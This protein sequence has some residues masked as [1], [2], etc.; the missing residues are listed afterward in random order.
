MTSLQP[1]HRRP[2]RG[3]FLG[4]AAVLL[5]WA[6]GSAQ[7]AAGWDDSRALALVEAA[8]AVRQASAVDSTLVAYQSRAQGFV[9]FFLDRPDEEEHTLIKAD[10]LAL[11]VYWRA[12]GDTRQRIVGMRDEKVLPTNIRYHLDHLTVVQDDFGDRIRMGDGDEVEAVVHPAAPGA[13][14]VYQYRLTDSLSLNY[15]GLTEPV[16][17]YQVQVRPRD[18]EAPGF[19]GTLYLDRASG[20]IVRM[21]F[22]FTP[23]SYVD[24]YLDYIR[25]SLDNALWLG[26]HWLPYRQEVELRRELPQLD[27]MAGSIIRGRWEVRGYEFNPELPDLLFSGPRVTAAPQRLRDS[28]VFD[29]DLYADLDASGL[30]P[31][32]SMEEIEAEVRSMALSGLLDGLAPLRL[33]VSSVSD[34]LRRDR[35]EGWTL[36]LGGVLRIRSVPLRVT[37]GFATAAE[38]PWLRGEA[39]FPAGS[40]KVSVQGHWNLLR[41]M[42]P[43]PGASRLV[44]TL[45]T[46]GGRDYLD[47]WWAGGGGAAYTRPLGSE[48]RL[49]LGILAERHRSGRLNLDDDNTSFRPVRPVAEGTL[50]AVDAGVERL[51]RGRGVFGSVGLLVGR[52]EETY[53]TLDATLG[54][55]RRTPSTPWEWWSALQGGW[56]SGAAPPQEL[57]LLGGRGT[58]PGFD[59]RG[60]VGNRYVLGSAWVRRRIA[61]PWVS[62]RLTASAGWSSL[63]DRALPAGWTGE[64]DP[65]LRGSAGAGLDLLWDVIQLDVARGL[66]DGD[67]TLFLSITARFRPWL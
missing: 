31:S 65:G 66:P 41:D 1:T 43:V 29:D 55:S 44:N 62:A 58:I 12:P 6:P 32:P 38:K 17:V 59:F 48:T 52:L 37:G 47:P 11:E 3:L 19:V 23:A 36:G 20:A 51:D 25:I 46:L 33:H 61:E 35:V 64:P 67:W 57:Q 14:A 28:Y 9:Y 13:E 50:L 4:A 26:K 15:V 21:A 49:Q 16:R 40:G 5:S 56:V 27:F 53:T 2:F 8:R 30:A 63:S 60:A 10:Q 39:E 42:G 22:T 24:P 7:E 45:A 34:A 54:W 18:L